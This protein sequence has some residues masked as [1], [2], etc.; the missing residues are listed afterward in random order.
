MNNLITELE[1]QEMEY[2]RLVNDQITSINN[3]K[4]EDYGKRISS[5]TN[6]NTRTD[7]NSTIYN[8]R[9]K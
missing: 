6:P 5:T 7:N 4:L 2:Y 1:V 9:I 8:K 3:V